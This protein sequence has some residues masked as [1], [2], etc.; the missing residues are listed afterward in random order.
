LVK[1]REIEGIRDELVDWNKHVRFKED[2]LSEE[3]IV[4]MNNKC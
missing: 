3:T 4:R 1:V 2:K